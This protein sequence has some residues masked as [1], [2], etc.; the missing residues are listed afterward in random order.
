MHF[1]IDDVQSYFEVSHWV[2]EIEWCIGEI[3]SEIEK[4][5]DNPKS[6]STKGLRS[7]YNQLTQTVDG[8]ITAYADKLEVAK[9]KAV[10]SSFWEIQSEN[11]EF[12][13]HMESKYGLYP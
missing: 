2:I 9:L 10:D 8:V 6:Y 5:F 4:S 1:F 3:G 11:N 13:E 7:I 12:L